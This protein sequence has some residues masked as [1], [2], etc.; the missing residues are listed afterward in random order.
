MRPIN[1]LSLFDGMSCGQ[2]AL[3]RAGIPVA[4]Y[5]ASEIDKHA[6]RVTKHNF[7]NTKHIGD[8]T[9][10][11]PNDLPPIDLVIGGSPCQG[12]SF[13]GK[14]LNFEDPRSA[15]FFEYVRLLKALNPTNFLM[16][17][18]KM[19]LDSER[20]ISGML[21]VNPLEINSNLLSAQNRRRLY[22][23]DIPFVGDVSDRGITWGDIREKNVNNQSL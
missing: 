13:S 3:K 4:N 19:E 9:K 8:V 10:I 20:V 5:F 23:T 16:E 7:P 14:Q 2:V 21:G 18:V 22:W 11:D 17:N 12:F 1:V 15:L 6:M